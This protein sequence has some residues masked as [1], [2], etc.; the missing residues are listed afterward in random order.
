MHPR[1]GCSPWHQS[2]R[3]HLVVRR[4]RA[5]RNS[6]TTQS[7]TDLREILG[8]CHSPLP[9]G[10]ILPQSIGSAPI[11]QLQVAPATFVSV[12]ACLGRHAPPPGNCR[13]VVRVAPGKDLVAA[14]TAT[15]RCNDGGDCTRPLASGLLRRTADLPDTRSSITTTYF[16]RACRLCYD[17]RSGTSRDLSP[18][19]YRRSP[20]RVLARGNRGHE[21]RRGCSSRPLVDGTATS[22]S[23]PE[24]PSCRSDEIPAEEHQRHGHAVGGQLPH[25]RILR[26]G[27]L[28]HRQGAR[29]ACCALH[30]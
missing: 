1:G 19:G 24:T 11:R 20:L 16:Q 12:D 18:S 26:S 30:R 6:V 28:G 5:V 23:L 15:S 17:H 29:I 4:A 27:N 2:V 21:I 22:A 13:V 8:P 9:H 3:R 14:K 25:P 10:A 7:G